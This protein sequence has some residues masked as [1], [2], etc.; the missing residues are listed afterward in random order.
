MAGTTQRDDSAPRPQEGESQGGEIHPQPLEVK[1][2]APRRIRRRRLK[3]RGL[4]VKVTLDTRSSVTVELSALNAKGRRVVVAKAA[5]ERALPRSVSFVLKLKPSRN[6]RNLKRLRLVA[7][8]TEDVGR[9]A[10][11]KRRIRFRSSS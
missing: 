5:K 4:P 8:V 6:V 3:E 7:T 2:S 1:L 10:T 11:A 9:S